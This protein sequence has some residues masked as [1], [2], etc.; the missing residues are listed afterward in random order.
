MDLLLFATII[1]L[2]CT[3][4]HLKDSSRSSRRALYC[5]ELGVEE[6]GGHASQEWGGPEDPVIG[7]HASDEGGPKRAC[8][9]DA[10]A[11]D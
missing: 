2:I 10:H 11:A 4:I 3:G 8:G 7:P 1:K 6:A 9:V 5:E